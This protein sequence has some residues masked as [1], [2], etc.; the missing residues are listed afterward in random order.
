MVFVCYDKIILELKAVKELE[1]SHRSQIYNY[2]KATG[3][4]L[5]FLINFGKYNELQISYNNSGEREFNKFIDLDTI[6]MEF[7]Y[8][9]LLKKDEKRLKIINHIIDLCHKRIEL[10]KG[11]FN[12][13]SLKKICLLIEISLK[14]YTIYEL[15]NLDKLIIYLD[16]NSRREIGLNLIQSLTNTI[17]MQNMSFLNVR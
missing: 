13:E 6:F 9:I 2:L 10:Y 17:D 5:G 11:Q 12:Y 15:T 1:D 8:K 3:F 16:Y 14:K 7:V 4:K